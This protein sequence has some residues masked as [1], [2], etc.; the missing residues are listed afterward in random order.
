MNHFPVVNN[1]GDSWETLNK[2]RREALNALDNARAALARMA[3]HGRNYQTAEPGAYTAAR[4]AHFD[5]RAL[6]LDVYNAVKAESVAVY[7]QRPD[8]LG[9]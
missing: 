1:N 7:E 6:L 3:P 8:R 9:G 5:L 4:E 2:D